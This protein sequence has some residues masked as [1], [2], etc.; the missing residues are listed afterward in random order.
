MPWAYS[1]KYLKEIYPRSVSFFL[2]NSLVVAAMDDRATTDPY[3]VVAVEDAGQEEPV[4]NPDLVEMKKESLEQNWGEEDWQ[5]DDSW[6]WNEWE[7]DESQTTVKAEPVDVG[8]GSASGS[9]G[10]SDDKSWSSWDKSWYDHHWHSNQQSWN[11]QWKPAKQEF[12]D[13]SS[14]GVYRFSFTLGS[15]NDTLICF[16]HF[17]FCP[18]ILST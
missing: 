18:L 2:R 10:W 7:W 11:N 6:G 1:L 9:K 12:L 3:E 5:W 15:A 16:Y 8:G 13:Q 17:L 4:A 14:G